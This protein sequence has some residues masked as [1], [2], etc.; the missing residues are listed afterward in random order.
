MRTVD[1]IRSVDQMCCAEVATRSVV[2]KYRSKV[3]Q[4]KVLLRSVAQS[5]LRG[6]FDQTRAQ[7]VL[8]RGIAHCSEASLRSVTHVT[9]ICVQKCCL[10]CRSGS[11]VADVCG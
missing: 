8:L 3:S 1:Q 5:W 4:S 9:E 11:S 2:Q 7:K 6:S 10:N